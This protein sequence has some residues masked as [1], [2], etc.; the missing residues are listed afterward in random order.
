MVVRAWSWL[1]VG[2]WSYS[3]MVVWVVFILVGS[4]RPWVLVV[5]GGVVVGDSGAVV[6]VFPHHHGMWALVVLKVTV[7]VAHM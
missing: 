5:E 1:S 3:V 6:I 4:H 7:D 2:G